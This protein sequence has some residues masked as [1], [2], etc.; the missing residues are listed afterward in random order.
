M[1]DREELEQSIA[2]LDED[3]LFLR[4]KRREMVDLLETPAA[5]Q[6]WGFMEVWYVTSG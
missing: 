6:H 5:A 4:T 2:N 3:I 1:N